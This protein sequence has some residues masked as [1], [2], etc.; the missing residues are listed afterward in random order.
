[1]PET[2][3]IEMRKFFSKQNWSKT[4][5]GEPYPKERPQLF[6][7]LV[8]RALAQDLISESKAAELLGLPLYEFQKKRNM[9]SARPAAH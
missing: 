4:E 2:H 9:Q 6:D 7:Q 1:M 5:P 3:Y 8:F